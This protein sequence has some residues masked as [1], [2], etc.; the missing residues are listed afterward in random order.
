MAKNNRK[1][2]YELSDI[3]R[4]LEE[5]NDP[6]VGEIVDTLVGLGHE[7][8]VYTFHDDFLGLESGLSPE[9]LSKKVDDFDDDTLDKFSDQIEDILYNANEIFYHLERDLN[10]NDQEEI[11]EERERLGLDDD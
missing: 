3:A 6:T 1:Q 9:L 5:L 11:R 10:E 7:D 2:F 4:K 8:R